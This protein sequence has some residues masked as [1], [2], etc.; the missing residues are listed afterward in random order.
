VSSLTNF[1]VAIFIA[2]SLGAEQFGAF[3][4]AY[5]TY[6]FVLN[7]S[8]GLATDPLLVRFS[9]TDPPVWRRAVASCTGTATVVGCAAGV[10]VLA[11][12]MLLSGTAKAA[13]LALGL[14]LPGLM[15]QDSW[16]F[17]FFAIGRGK[18]AFLNDLVW[19]LVQVPAFAVL[20][21]TGHMS[22][23]WLVLAWGAAAAVAASV[24]PFQ[25]RVLPRLSETQTWLTRQ[26]DL[27]V[28]YLA[29]NTASG[30]AT[31]LRIY[32]IGL[33]LGLAAVGYVRAAETLMGPFLVLSMG[34]SWAAVPE[35]VRF[36]RRS[37]RHLRF[38][39][40]SLSVGLAL[41]AL[42]W[43]VALLV[44]LPR[45]LGAALLGSIWRPAYPLILPATVTVVAGCF[46]VGASAGM[47]A[48]GAARQSLRVQVLSSAAFLVLSI[49]GALTGGAAGAM[50][51]TALSTVIAALLW[52]WQLRASL[53][54][55]ES[56]P[57][58]AM[59]SAPD[60]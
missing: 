16:R 31:Q 8:R 1:A 59:T 36:L 33:I 44:L 21:A 50:R 29:E 24:G 56:A 60:P 22:V 54:E 40:L 5:V 10:F 11:A 6:S 7:A 9:G 45:G 30:G 4:L 47:R 49:G 19:A 28:R 17:A 15:L 58:Y 38:F 2:R 12:A 37:P 14:T 20:W 26:R 3:S 51:G 53:R 46:S 35:A 55:F 27:G 32:S 34:I 57:S 18:Q 41:T 25:A 43:G 48:L 39:C 23:F 42:A 52:W 13:F